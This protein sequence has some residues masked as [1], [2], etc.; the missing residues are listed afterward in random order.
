MNIEHNQTYQENNLKEQFLFL[1]RKF[2]TFALYDNDVYIDIRTVKG[3]RWNR[4]KKSEG[5]KVKL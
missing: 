4:M 2:N 5:G 1:G 3:A